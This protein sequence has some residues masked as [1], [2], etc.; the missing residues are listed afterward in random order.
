MKPM[1]RGNSKNGEKN[2]GNEYQRYIYVVDKRKQ[3]EI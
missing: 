3:I 1:G 2:S